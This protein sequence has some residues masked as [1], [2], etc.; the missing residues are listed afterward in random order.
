MI[1]HKRFAVSALILAFGVMLTAPVF[2]TGGGV[3]D[4]FPEDR[5]SHLETTAAEGNTSN[6][7]VHKFRRGIINSALGWTAYKPAFE[8]NGATGLASGTAET[9]G[10]T[11]VGAVELG[12]FLFPNPRENGKWNYNGYQDPSEPWKA[13]G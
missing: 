7:V 11:V 13:R 6:Q 8:Q 4:P 10:H 9:I 1:T 3:S 2:A 5:S 12:T